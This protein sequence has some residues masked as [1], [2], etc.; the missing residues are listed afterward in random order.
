[1]GAGKCEAWLAPLDALVAAHPALTSRTPAEPGARLPGL[2]NF[3]V[4]GARGEDM[5]YLLDQAGLACSTG[6]ACAAGVA[7]PSHVLVAM[8]LDEATAAAA[9]R[10]SLGHRSTAADVEALVAALPEA[11]DRAQAARGARGGWR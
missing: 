11:V 5:V 10:V 7:G 4:V 1:G 8:G 2:R 3:T 6:S 9:V